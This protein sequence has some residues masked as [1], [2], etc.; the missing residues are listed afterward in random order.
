M[1]TFQAGTYGQLNRDGTLRGIVVAGT[2]FEARPECFVPV[3]VDAQPGFDAATQVLVSGTPFLQGGN[4]HIP[5]SIVT[6]SAD[7]QNT[8]TDTAQLVLKA[9]A[10]FTALK[11]HTATAAQTQDILALL[12][13][14][15][16][17]QDGITV[18]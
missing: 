2:S 14:Y 7:Q 6:L 4:A 5:W 10:A 18:T 9:Q 11:A 16:A 13:R 15:V 8:I 12:L 1:S 17:K 3:V